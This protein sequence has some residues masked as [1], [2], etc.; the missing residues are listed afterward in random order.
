[1][2]WSLFDRFQT[3]AASRRAVAD[4]RRSEYNLR[5]AQLDAEREIVQYLNSLIEAKESFVVASGTVEQAQED[6]RLA[7]ERFRVGAGTSLDVINAQ[8]NLTSARKDEVDA[9]ANYLIAKAQLARAV[10]RR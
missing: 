5:Q 9:V 6:L 3:K 10:G 7:N 1:M 2:N 4:R 8:V